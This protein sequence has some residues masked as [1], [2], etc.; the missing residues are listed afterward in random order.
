MRAQP[1]GTPVN[2]VLQAVYRTLSALAGLAMVGALVAVLLGVAGRQLGFNIRGLD[3]YA[4]YCIAATLFLALPETLRRGDHIRVTLLLQ[5]APPR[6][7]RALEAWSLLAGLGLALYLAWFAVRL[8]WV[9]WDTHDISQGADAT[10]LWMPQVAMALGCI[11][12]AAAFAEALWA[13]WGGP[14]FFAAPAAEAAHVE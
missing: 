7:R 11:G 4:G 13:H 14:R 8:V 6:V 12:F 10:P 3:A 9:S 5:K 1:E 2:S